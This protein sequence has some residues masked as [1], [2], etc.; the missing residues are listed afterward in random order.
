MKVAYVYLNMGASYEGADWRVLKFDTET[1]K[2]IEEIYIHE[3]YAHDACKDYKVISRKT[4]N[5]M[6]AYDDDFKRISAQGDDYGRVTGDFIRNI[7]DSR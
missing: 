2:I 3:D 4:F 5:A 7:L 6:T 1:D